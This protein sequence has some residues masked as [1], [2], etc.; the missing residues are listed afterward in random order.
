MAS[1]LNVSC[2]QQP[3]KAVV[4][5]ISSQK[6][7]ETGQGFDN[8]NKPPTSWRDRLELEIFGGKVSFLTRDPSSYGF[9]DPIELKNNPNNIRNVSRYT[10]RAIQF[11]NH[12]NGTNYK[13]VKL[14]GAKRVIVANIFLYIT[15]EAKDENSDDGQCKT[16]YAELSR[17]IRS[18]AKIKYCGLEPKLDN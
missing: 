13:C 5:K 12:K 7:Q 11:Y 2:E 17:G 9:G 1:Q 14:K 4:W 6:L 16:F 18:E 15:F 10:H 3:G 8:Q